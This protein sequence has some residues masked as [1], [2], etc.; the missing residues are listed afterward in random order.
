MTASNNDGD[1][2]FLTLFGAFTVSEKLIL[3]MLWVE[4]ELAAIDMD[5]LDQSP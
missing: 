4:G 5:N 1:D 2:D 3:P